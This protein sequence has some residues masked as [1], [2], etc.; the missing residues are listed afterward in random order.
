MIVVSN[1]SPLIIL[2][3][4][5]RLELLR[6]LYE[7][8]ILPAEV[9]GE[10]V[11]PGTNLPGS[12]QIAQAIWLDVRRLA[13]P[14]A[15]SAAEG[16]FSLARGELATVLLAEE[17]KADLVLMDDRAGRRLAASRGLRTRG[18]VGILEAAFQLGHVSDLRQAYADLVAQR[19][20]VDHRI[21]NAS[22]AHFG[23]ALL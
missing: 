9:H 3:K 12:A 2:A 22:L 6:S 14:E 7:R 21:L 20:Y 13:N 8:I 11:V 1:A 17:L 10:V 19:A 18:C 23:L 4:V 15:L 16:E 5:N